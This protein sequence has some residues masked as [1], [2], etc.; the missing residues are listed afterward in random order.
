MSHDSGFPG[1]FF[2]KLISL[3]IYSYTLVKYNLHIYMS[4]SI[5]IDNVP[6]NY[7]K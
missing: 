5:V 3:F 6:S 1:V 7:V 4:S 2:V